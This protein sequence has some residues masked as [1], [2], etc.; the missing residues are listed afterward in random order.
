MKTQQKYCTWFI[1]KLGIWFQKEFNQTPHVSEF[2]SKPTKVKVGFSL[3]NNILV[4]VLILYEIS[5]I[6]MGLYLTVPTAVVQS[7][8]PKCLTTRAHY[9]NGSV[10]DRPLDD[11]CR[12]CL[13]L[14]TASFDSCGYFACCQEQWMNNSSKMKQGSCTL[15]APD[16][17]FPLPLYW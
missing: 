5:V 13:V 12:C 4:P 14:W 17:I 2:D 6:C 16:L 15:A 1:P 11:L 10:S 3:D 7:T 9:L 8:Y